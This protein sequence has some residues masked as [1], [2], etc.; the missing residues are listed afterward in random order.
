MQSQYVGCPLTM[1]GIFV[2]IGLLGLNYLSFH[3]G[4]GLFM[5]FMVV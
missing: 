5:L 4:M 2:V 1:L 3:L